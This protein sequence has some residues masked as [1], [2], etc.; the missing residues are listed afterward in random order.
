ML[1]VNVSVV[2]DFISEVDLKKS[3]LDWRALSDKNVKVWFK[4]IYYCHS[5][6]DDGMEFD[7]CQFL[8]VEETCV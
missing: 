2:I 7:M 4:H 1:D 6:Q 5:L 3:S 8:P